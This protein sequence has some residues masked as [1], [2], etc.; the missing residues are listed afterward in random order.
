MDGGHWSFSSYNQTINSKKNK[1][2]EKYLL[3]LMEEYERV[4]NI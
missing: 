2:F 4:R 3:F 1:T